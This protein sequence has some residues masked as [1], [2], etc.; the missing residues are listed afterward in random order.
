MVSKD[1]IDL[2]T[3]ALVGVGIINP[4]VQLGI[5]GAIGTESS[6]DPKSEYSY[7]NTSNSRLRSIFSS[8]LNLYSE[9]QLTSLKTNDVAFYDVIY[10]GRYGN[11][12]LGDGWKYRG[13]GFNQLTFKDNY[14][15]FGSI[16]G[17]DLVNNP[18]LLNDFGVAAK[19]A[20]AY[21]AENFKI[22]TNNGMLKSKIGVSSVNDIKD[23][24]TGTKLAL[25]VNAGWGTDLSSDFLKE[26]Y[27]K[28]LANAKAILETIKANPG[29]TAGVSILLLIG[30]FFLVRSLI[31]KKKKAG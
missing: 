23:V 8:R 20:A 9:D 11:T 2:M 18:D 16:V 25:Q 14:K 13:R 21:F 6:F 7:K 17:V 24:E 15:K 28:E 27:Q 29:A 10:G 19:V 22:G 5:L 1:K 3:V 12:N 30:A 31:K 4:F 26:V